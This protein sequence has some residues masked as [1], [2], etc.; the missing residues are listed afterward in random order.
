MLKNI[1]SGTKKK[2]SRNILIFILHLDNR[3]YVSFKNTKSLLALFD[4]FNLLLFKLYSITLKSK[5]LLFKLYSI[6]LKSK[7]YV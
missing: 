1:T 5:L 7:F 2:I 6:T 3:K 4:L